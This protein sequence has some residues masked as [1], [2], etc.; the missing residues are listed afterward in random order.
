[1]T[2]VLSGPGFQPAD[3]GWR[4][5]SKEGGHY[6]IYSASHDP[7]AAIVGLREWFD[8]DDKINSLNFLLFST[9]GVH[10]CYTTIEEIERSMKRYPDGPPEGDDCPEDYCTP[11]ITFLIVQPRIVGMT[12]GNATIRDMDDVRWVKR[13]RKLTAAVIA[14]T[15]PQSKRS[16]R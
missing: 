5:S 10:G 16:K 9:S 14:K 1:M 4:R 8:S 15:V 3:M 2:V 11:E 6:N 13:M 12:Y 7:D